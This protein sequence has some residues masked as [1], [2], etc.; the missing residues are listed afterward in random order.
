MCLL[1]PPSLQI[2]AL[3]WEN[4]PGE[5]K[6]RPRLQ[7]VTLA[8]RDSDGCVNIER[9][10]FCL[11]ALIWSQIHMPREAARRADRPFYHEWYST[12]ELIDP[13]HSAHTQM[14]RLVAVSYLKWS[15][16]WKSYW[17]RGRGGGGG[18]KERETRQRGRRRRDKKKRECHWRHMKP[19]V[20][21]D[22]MMTWSHFKT[23]Y[24]AENYGREWSSSLFVLLLCDTL[25]QQWRADGCV[26]ENQWQAAHSVHCQN[27]Q[28][29]PH[30]IE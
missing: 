30:R 1:D 2:W 14:H 16:F 28:L 18:E 24:K 29:V 21:A 12:E 26:R 5:E 3:K 22:M 8:A 6:Y 7:H 9:C 19:A 15:G 25:S 10:V 23:T 13:S 4:L 17:L 11:T 27:L 20:P